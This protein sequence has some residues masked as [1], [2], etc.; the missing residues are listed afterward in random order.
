MLH[1]SSNN[2]V[3]LEVKDKNTM[4][5]EKYFVL[6]LFFLLNLISGVL[7]ANGPSLKLVLETPARPDLQRFRMHVS[8]VIFKGPESCKKSLT[9]VENEDVLTSIDLPTLIT[10]NR[11][12]SKLFDA[13]GHYDIAEAVYEGELEIVKLLLKNRSDINFNAPLERWIGIG[14]N[15]NDQAGRTA[16]M[17]AL[18]Q[19]NPEMLELLLEAARGVDVHVQDERGMTLLHH[20]AEVGH[21]G[22]V[23]AL[24]EAGA[25]VNAQNDRDQ[26]PLHIAAENSIDV[27]NALIAAGAEVN[28]QNDRDQTPLHIAAENSHIDVVN[29]LI[30]AGA[31]VNALNYQGRT[32]LHMAAKNNNV[33]IIKTLVA[34]EA[35]PNIQDRMNGGNTRNTPLHTAISQGNT[36]AATE[37]MKVTNLSI[38]NGE[39]ETPE[40]LKL[41]L[42]E[43]QS[44]NE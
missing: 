44:A 24:I 27:V 16:I 43:E 20:A 15:D 34:A 33:K 2:I 32:P 10:F 6:V 13:H 14:N 39:G 31:E 12:Q 26:T 17:I 41:T 35:D 9:N 8:P 19:D 3:Q 30:A 38:R 25:E 22:L 18:H 36:E 11:Y 21:I 29:A 1:T 28:A 4:L 37:L 7:Y 23:N 40:E 5:R 42:E